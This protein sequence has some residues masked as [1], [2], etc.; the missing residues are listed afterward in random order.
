[1]T[2]ARLSGQTEAFAPL[3]Q[4]VEA[5]LQEVASDQ[6]G[7]LGVY[8]GQVIRAGGKRLRPLLVILCSGL[9]DPSHQ[10]LIDMAAAA[11]L[12]HTASL[13]HDDILDQA[14]TRRGATTIN[15]LQ[16]NHTAVLAGDFLFAAAFDLLT[17]TGRPEALALMTEAIRA[18]CQAEIEQKEAVFQFS[19]TESRYLGRI[20]K[21]TAALLA[22]CCGA[23]A[24]AGGAAPEEVASLMAFGRNLGLCFQI[25]DDLLD[26]TGD[27]ATLGKPAGSDLAQGILTLP[28][29]YLLQYFAF[30]QESEL[31]AGNSNPVSLPNRARLRK[32]ARS[33]SY[34]QPDLDYIRQAVCQSPALGQAHQKALDYA[35]QAADCLAGSTPETTHQALLG[36]VEQLAQR[37]R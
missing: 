32:I 36:L 24:L 34:A 26:F 29:I 2:T 4:A 12:I 8:A 31:A 18:M 9:A 19:V 13:I 21:K 23:G 30:E 17:C 25:T 14:T 7:I 15:H 35:R 3:L 5:R 16:G 6:A 10:P 27:S 33:G 37:Q 28:V 22:A 11:E 20:E 1:M